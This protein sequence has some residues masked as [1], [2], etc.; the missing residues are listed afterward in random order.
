M[1]CVF[2]FVCV[3][4]WAAFLWRGCKKM[5]WL[6]FCFSAFS[7]S[8]ALRFWKW[9]VCVVSGDPQLCGRFGCWQRRLCLLIGNAPLPLPTPSLPIKAA[10][11]SLWLIMRYT[12]RAVCLRACET[13]LCINR[14]P[15]HNIGGDVFANLSKQRD[16]DIRSKL[17][18][19]FS[20][21]WRFW[22]FICRYASQL[23]NITPCYRS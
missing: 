18:I 7:F 23:L 20:W 6:I 10:N 13:R 15:I 2:V 17:W 1:A 4:C 19:K 16:V 11:V 3:V 5:S 8:L 22:Q 14:T 9:G 12:S 21:L